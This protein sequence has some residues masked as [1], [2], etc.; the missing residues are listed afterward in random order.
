MKI[1]IARPTTDALIETFIRIVKNLV[2]S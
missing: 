2:D 1:P